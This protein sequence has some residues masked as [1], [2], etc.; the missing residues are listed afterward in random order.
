MSYYEMRLESI[1]GLGAN[2]AGKI[3]GELGALYMNMNSSSFSS[4]GSEKRGSPVKAYVRWC[5]SNEQIRINTPVKTPN[6]LAIFHENL[7]G[8]EDV[9]A[10]ADKNT[11]II[12]NTSLAPEEIRKMFKFCAGTL[13]CI[14]ALSLAAECKTRINMIMLGAIVRACGFVPLA[15]LE[16]AITDTL[17]KKYP[18]ALSSNINGIRK[19][20]EYAKPYLI[21]NDNLYPY[22]QY[23][24]IKYNWGWDN[25]PIGGINPNF[26]SMISNDLSSSREG[27]V[28]VFN[29]EKCINCGL[30]EST[31]PDFVYQFVE[32]EYKGKP[33]MINL[34]PDYHHCKGCLRCVEICPTHAITEALEKNVDISKLH[35]RNQQL[36]VDKLEFEHTGANSYM[37]CESWTT[38]ELL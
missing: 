21:P 31:C 16:R 33:A 19:G 4:Y 34:G 11:S 37:R 18:K 10:G 8:K 1:G 6:I 9:I 25:A 15:E 17:G 20:Y 35:V 28:P 32:G 5:D 2:L 29:K 23:T 30:C 26:G 13:Y 27:Y 7:A 12:V 36:I 14:D 24:D 3:L 22:K 38:N